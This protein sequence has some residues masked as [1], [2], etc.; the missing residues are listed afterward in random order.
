MYYHCF[1]L[2]HGAVLD[3]PLLSPRSLQ[4]HQLSIGSSY[5]LLHKVHTALH[6]YLYLPHHEH[7]HQVHVLL[8]FIF[9][10]SFFSFSIYPLALPQLLSNRLDMLWRQNLA[11]DAIQS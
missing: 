5:V 6:L 8:L 2:Y 3:I 11:E 9:N 10:T 1:L 7:L 4:I